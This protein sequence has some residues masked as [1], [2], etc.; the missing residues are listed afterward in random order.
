MKPDFLKQAKATMMVVNPT[1]IAKTHLIKDVVIRKPRKK[2][3]L[4]RKE[5]DRGEDRLREDVID[6]FRKR[7]AIVK[8]IENSITGKRGDSLPDLWVFDVKTKWAGW[9][10]LK[11]HSDLRDGQR[12][13]KWLCGEM[14]V[15]HLVV[16]SLEDIKNAGM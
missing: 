2:E 11:Y 6:Y 13:F 9:L 7:G 3:V 16:Y 1:A 5:Y 14:R 12:H 10:E 4:P 15:N 8:R